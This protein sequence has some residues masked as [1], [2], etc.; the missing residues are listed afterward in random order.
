[1]PL[2]PINGH[3]HNVPQTTSVG[4]F[5]AHKMSQADF[6]SWPEPAIRGRR[7]H[8]GY[9]ANSG[10]LSDIAVTAAPDPEPDSPSS[11]NLNSMYL[12]LLMANPRE[13]AAFSRASMGLFSL[14]FGGVSA[15][16][17]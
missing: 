5:G 17:V 14:L 3:D 2:E 10:Q 6:C 1:M 16:L 15:V 7:H 4:L 8:S 9:R 13:T 12:A 11:F